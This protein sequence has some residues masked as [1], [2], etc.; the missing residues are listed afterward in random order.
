MSGR[1]GSIRNARVLLQ[2]GLRINPTSEDLWLQSFHLELHYI[3]K[4]KGRRNILQPGWKDNVNQS[5]EGK[6]LVADCEEEEEDDAENAL[7]DTLLPLIVYKN[8]IKAIP[9][10]VS[11]R[12]RFLDLCGRF[13]DTDSIQK[14]IR[15]SIDRDCSDYVDS[16]ISQ[17]VHVLGSQTNRKTN[18]GHESE[19]NHEED[20]DDD[21]EDNEVDEDSRKRKAEDI[22]DTS[23]PNWAIIGPQ[24]NHILQA[25][26]DR[27]SSE[28]M[29]L[30]AIR[31]LLNTMEHDTVDGN[32]DFLITCVDDLFKKAKNKGIESPALLL[33][34]ANWLVA[35][36]KWIEA[37]QML[38]KV[39]MVDKS[40]VKD[41]QLW[42]KWAEVS[43][44]SILPTELNPT[45]SPESILQHALEII[46][47]HDKGHF[48]IASKLFLYHFH[49][50][51]SIEEDDH[52]RT[53]THSLMHLFDKLLLLS[54]QVSSSAENGTS[55][56]ML[57]ICSA[58]LQHALLLD[59][60]DLIRGIYNRI[61]YSS[62]FLKHC[63]V[64]DEK[65]IEMIK[66]LFDSSISFERKHL[67]K[68]KGKGSNRDQSRRIVD[69]AIA[70]FQGNGMQNLA[71]L[72]HN[73][74]NY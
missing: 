45:H 54:V 5:S 19:T 12:L 14:E 36:G 17:A 22:H 2:R 10:T 7:Y 24:L 3:Q 20:D 15:S 65:S 60:T 57:K 63:R 33:E 58:Y 70:F 61:F 16:W 47:M 51:G 62:S 18:N 25:A 64:D 38:H 30:Y 71:R 74:F 4:L 72:Y 42:V 44:K 53:K 48:D 66:L 59:D 49:P 35:C 28:E 67:K 46:P 34:H 43:E 55:A 11:F 50:L 32:D 37:K 73:Q 1:G 31:F 27:I 6:R 39:L 29:Y 68:N 52:N 21:D 23:S 56:T 9:A 41:S 26:T 13:P 69:S 40:F 8:A